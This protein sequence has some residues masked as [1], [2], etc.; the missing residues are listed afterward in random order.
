MTQDSDAPHQVTA[1]NPVRRHSLPIAPDGPDR[2]MVLRLVRRRIES[3]HGTLENAISTHAL[4]FRVSVLGACNLSCRFCHNEGAP[5]RGRLDPSLA[6]EAIAA[7]QELGF[8][9]VQFTG[10]E[11]LLHPELSAFVQAAAEFVEDVGVTTNGTLLNGRM[12]R[13]IDSGLQR[14]HIS[15]QAEA[16][17]AV[18]QRSRW[19]VPDWL[20]DVL[21][22]A[23]SGGVRVRLNLPVAV[24]DLGN[25]KSFLE[26]L[27]ESA[28]RVQIFSILP[29]AADDPE[30]YADYIRQLEELVAGENETRPVGSDRAITLRGYKPPAGV[31]CPDCTERAFCREQSHSLR[32]GADGILR[33]CLASR[34]WDIETK[35][36]LL[37]KQLY[38]AT[39]LALDFV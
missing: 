13:L 15:L 6:R 4:Y 30:T 33:P 10:G 34:R 23:E 37:R 3:A 8:R 7:A 31:R 22:F 26:L 21:C 20:S 27:R 17:L 38:E 2:E 12:R 39:L 28:C 29:E 5:T 35:P 16:L 18:G 1:A 9:R 25:A 14:L 32:L 19:T 11:P 24:Y 36:D